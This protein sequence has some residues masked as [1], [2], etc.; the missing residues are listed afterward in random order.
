MPNHSSLPQT[1]K[2]LGARIR[3]LRKKKGWTQDEFAVIC[4]I[5]RSHMGKIER[6]EPTGLNWLQAEFL[7][8]ILDLEAL[9]EVSPRQ[10]ERLRVYFTTEVSEVEMAKEEGKSDHA[11]QKSNRRALEALYQYLVMVSPEKAEEFPRDIGA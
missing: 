7:L 2:A 3:Q 5:H 10:Q 8:T 11:I 9:G 1:A 6:G 4:E